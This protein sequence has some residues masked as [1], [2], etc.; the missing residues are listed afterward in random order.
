MRSGND[1]TPFIPLAGHGHLVARM[2]MQSVKAINL[3]PE[4][5]LKPTC[6]EQ[7]GKASAFCMLDQ[8]AASCLLPPL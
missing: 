7:L 2:N 4:V 3:T 5:P 1:G 6:K 8:I